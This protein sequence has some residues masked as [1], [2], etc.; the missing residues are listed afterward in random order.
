LSGASQTLRQALEV[1]H[2]WRFPETNLDWGEIEAT[3]QAIN[4][5]GLPWSGLG[6]G[7]GNDY[8]E[9]QTEFKAKK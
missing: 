9:M 4:E 1:R 7:Q 3:A 2:R 6:Y 8:D 5:P